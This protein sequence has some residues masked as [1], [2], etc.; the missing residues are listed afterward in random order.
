MTCSLI[1]CQV[2]VKSSISDRIPVFSAPEIQYD[3]R[4]WIVS[5]FYTFF[6]AAAGYL[7][8]GRSRHGIVVMSG[9]F[10]GPASGFPRLSLPRITYSRKF[11]FFNGILSSRCIQP[12]A[13]KPVSERIQKPVS[14]RSPRPVSERSRRPV[15]DSC[16]SPVSERSRSPVSEPSRRPVLSRKPQPNTLFFHEFPA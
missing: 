4:M 10:S 14:E 13:Q 12:L 3:H 9:P 2:L 5:S 7:L 16:H 6:W 15:S 8:Q 1:K 11:G